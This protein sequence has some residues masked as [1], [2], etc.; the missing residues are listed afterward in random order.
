MLPISRNATVPL[1]PAGEGENTKCDDLRVMI[2]AKVGFQRGHEI[3]KL[4]TFA[5]SQALECARGY[6]TLR[7]YRPQYRIDFPSAIM[8]HFLFKKLNQ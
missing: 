1:P 2:C 3:V 8:G 7:Q 4:T 6:S 5:K